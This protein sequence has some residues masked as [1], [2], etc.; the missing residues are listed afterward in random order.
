MEMNTSAFRD[1]FLRFTKEIKCP[2]GLS[3]FEAARLQPG[4]SLQRTY[5]QTPDS[6]NEQRSYPKSED[7]I[8]TQGA[9]CGLDEMGIL[10]HYYPGVR[11]FVGFLEGQDAQSATV[12]TGGSVVLKID[13]L[14]S[15]AV[16]R[17][18]TVFCSAPNSFSLKQVPGAAEIGV[19]R[20]VEG[21]NR[22]AVAFRR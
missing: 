5:E 9:A 6:E 17:G 16:D 22:A 19:I 3:A 1:P 10:C 21:A 18:R 11:R 8:L 13:G 2:M 14:T 20:H 7:H 4:P 12:K 15:T